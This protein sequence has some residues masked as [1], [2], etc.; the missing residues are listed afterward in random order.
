MIQLYRIFLWGYLKEEKTKFFFSLLGISLGITLYFVT[1]LNSFRAEESVLDLQLGFP[2]E[3]FYGHFIPSGESSGKSQFILKDINAILPDSLGMDPEIQREGYHFDQ[4]HNFHQFVFL[5][6]DLITLYSKTEEKNSNRK[7]SPFSFGVS[8]S[9]AK[10]ILNE[11]DSKEVFLCNQKIKLSA[12]NTYVINKEGNFVLTDILQAQKIC[13]ATGQIDQIVIYFKD[14]ATPKNFGPDKEQLKSIEKKGWVF[15][16]KEE[17]KDRAGKALGSL[18]INL[19]IVSLVSVLIS[20]FMVANTFTGLYLSRKKELGIL[21]SIGTSRLQNLFLFLSQSFLLGIS[22]SLLGILFGYGLNRSDFLLSKSTITDPSQ[23]TSYT[24]VPN[25]ILLTSLLI[26]VFGALVSGILSSLKSYRI[27]PI[28]LLRERSHLVEKSVLLSTNLIPVAGIILVFLG[29]FLGLYS[30][31]KS[32]WRGISGIGCI[33]LGFVSLFPFLIQKTISFFFRIIDRF[34]FFPSLKIAWEEIK[35]EPWTHSLTSA[36]VMLSVSLVLTLTCLTGSYEKTLIRWTEEEN[37]FEYSVINPSKLSMGKP[38]VPISL[39]SKL[40]ESNL[41]SKIQPFVIRP[42]FVI[43]DNF[44]TIHAFPF[45]KDWNKE[46]V[47]VSSN[48]C[49]LEQLCKG[50]DLEI[51]TEKKGK[52]AIRIQGEKEHFFSERGTLMMDLDQYKELFS[53]SNYNSIRVKFKENDTNEKK[54]KIL[55]SVLN[56]ETKELDVLDQDS[57]KQLYL[58]GMK[59]V[60]SILDSLKS[61]AVFISILAMTSSLIYNLREKTHL[62]SVLRSI[63]LSRFQ[64]FSM[65]FFQS[66]YLIGFGTVLG[67]VNSFILSP[68]V[69]YGINRNAFGWVLDFY[70]PGST[71]LILF[72][73]LP[74]ISAFVSFYPYREAS[75]KALRKG[76]NYE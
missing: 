29:I 60:F 25:E 42:K 36:T 15:E 45:P 16:S 46:E 18:R 13:G 17:V 4:N 50:D 35:S 56:S 51:L 70:Y 30:S 59:T 32:L 71:L 44:Y 9:L 73:S 40:E 5:G 61:M 54:M 68:I 12:K 14:N 64:L 75:R 76:L 69:I 74:L 65:V 23:I 58:N 3:S 11:N 7:I 21:L 66:F 49:F 37:D 10:Q 19:T 24:K 63:G 22:G 28:D 72:L 38:G 47:L 57:L 31:P 2:G 1:S 48:F 33:I 52:I 20:F 53:V 27:R 41:F 62:I 67:I 39:E 26:G 8:G 6:K 55:K 43:G 34:D